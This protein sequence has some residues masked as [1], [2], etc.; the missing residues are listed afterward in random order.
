MR[1]LGIETDRISEDRLDSVRAL[2]TGH[3]AGLWYPSTGHVLDSLQVVR[4]FSDAARERGCE[5]R[6][7][8]VSA[9]EQCGT[10]LH[11]LTRE[12]TAHVDA[13]VVCAGPWSAPLL[14]PFGLRVPLESVRGYHVELPQHAPLFD[15]SVLY[16]DHYLLVT[17]MS[18]RLRATSYM[19]F[20][21]PQAAPDPRKPAHLRRLLQGFGYQCETDGPS[22]VGSRPV[23]PDYLPGIG[24]AAIP[25]R[26]FYALGHHHIGLTLAAI[27]GE[28][29]ADLVAERA[30]RHD[31]RAFDLRRFGRAPMSPAAS[32]RARPCAA[33][34]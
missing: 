14:E 30:P 26:L 11:V 32:V 2:R 12:S 13:A 18:G 6:R 17:P 4:A 31:V 21:P 7:G 16:A 28:L 22:W 5:L 19:E 33:T 9:L 3:A 23:L 24:R 1:D 27:T 29:V 20:E 10:G 25:A 15:S 8:E 34:G